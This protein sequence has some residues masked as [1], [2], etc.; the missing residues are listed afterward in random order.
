MHIVAGCVLDNHI[1]G[2]PRMKSYRLVLATT[3]DRCLPLS[4][5]RS[6]TTHGHTMH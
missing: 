2:G 4:K 1:P 6:K 3:V 5:A